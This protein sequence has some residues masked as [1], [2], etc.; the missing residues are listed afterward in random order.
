MVSRYMHVGKSVAQWIEVVACFCYYYFFITVIG[1]KKR[2][3][4]LWKVTVILFDESQ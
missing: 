3:E 1:Q 2:R 4:L